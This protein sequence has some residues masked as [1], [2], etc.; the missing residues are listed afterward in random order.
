MKNFSSL[1]KTL[2]VVIIMMTPMVFQA[3]NHDVK[4]MAK[5]IDKVYITASPDILENKG[6][7][8]TVTI[9]ADF[10]AR[11]FHKKAVMNITPVLIYEDGETELPSMN[12]IGEK[13]DGEGVVV[14]KK[15]GGSYS[16]TITIPYEDKM[17]NSLLIVEPI[18]YKFK[19]V[20]HPNNHS[21]K[22]NAEFAMANA[23][24]V[25]EGV[26][27]TAHKIDKNALHTAYAEPS[28]EDKTTTDNGDIFF[29]V[30]SDNINW[31]VPLNKTTQNKS[32]IN[33]LTSH[34]LKGWKIQ[35]IE[36]TGWASPEGAIVY[37]TTLAQKRAK[38]TE[39]FLKKRLASLSAQDKSKL[40]D[41]SIP[42]F[43]IFKSLSLSKDPAN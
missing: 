1:F 8:V 41:F 15:H 22:E 5:R 21:I 7:T 13:V 20:V 31:S 11:Y 16:Y 9:E 29:M 36:I 37:N 3:K 34:I 6:N 38:T 28:M 17:Y 39:D 23:F 43:I 26:I 2:L 4:N 30:N 24:L 27:N 10:P 40:S 14:S 42:S 18:V 25:A 32:A 33:E 12:F 35:D 19:E